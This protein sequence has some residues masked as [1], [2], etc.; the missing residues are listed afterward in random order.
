MGSNIDLAQVSDNTINIPN[1]GFETGDPIVYSNGGDTS[2]G[3]LTD[4]QTYYV[5]KADLLKELDII[6][7]TSRFL[8]DYR[9]ILFLWRKENQLDCRRKK[10]PI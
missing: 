2:I 9:L 1:H 3:G 5:Y 8:P 10:C 7:A 6:L 4:E